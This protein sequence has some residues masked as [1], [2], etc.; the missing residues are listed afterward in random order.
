MGKYGYH[1]PVQH[2]KEV[3]ALP[4]KILIYCSNL[5][6]TP[7]IN[8]RKAFNTRSTEIYRISISV[9][10]FLNITDLPRH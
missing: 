2:I 10:L 7:E 4:K 5:V 3:Q 1:D 8:L 9:H 6:F